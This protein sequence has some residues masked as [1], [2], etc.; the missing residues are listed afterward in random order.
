M[1]KVYFIV[2]VVIPY[3]SYIIKLNNVQ[4]TKICE[5]GIIT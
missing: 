1:K 5:V 4:C 3:L 2:Q